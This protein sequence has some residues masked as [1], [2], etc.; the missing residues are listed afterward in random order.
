[1]HFA[2]NQSIFLFC[3]YAFD[4]DNLSF[5]VIDLITELTGCQT[6]TFQQLR[7]GYSTARSL[8]PR[9]CKMY[10]SLSGVIVLC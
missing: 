3:F 8:H 9:V 7:V 4:V 5:V 1:V 10:C 6:A 2:I